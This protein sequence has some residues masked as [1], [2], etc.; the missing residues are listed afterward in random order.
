MVRRERR[1]HADGVYRDAEMIV[2]GSRGLGTVAGA[3][4]GSVSR[5]LVELAPVP[6]LVAKENVAAAAEPPEREPA[7]AS[8]T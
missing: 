6:V 8:S 5:A 7:R 2:V 3:L 4:L 1:R